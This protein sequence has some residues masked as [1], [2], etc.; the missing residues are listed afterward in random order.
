MPLYDYRCASCDTRFEARHAMSEVAPR[1]PRCGAEA[2]LIFVT[3]PAVHGH[4]ARG[5][6]LAAQSLEPQPASHGPGCPCC[7]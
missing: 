1:C 4:M 3:A 6:Q 2:R 5:R 7:H